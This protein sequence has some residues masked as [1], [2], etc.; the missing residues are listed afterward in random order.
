MNTLLFSVSDI[1]KYWDTITQYVNPIT[2]VKQAVI[3]GFVGFLIV[4]ITMIVLRKK[5]LINRRHWSLKILSYVYMVF[6]PLFAGYCFTQWFGVHAIEKEL[7]KNIPTYLGDANSAFNKYLKAEVEKVVAERHL[8][9]TGHEVLDKGVDMAANTVSSL[10]QTA[11]DKLETQLS[12]YLTKT[13]FVKDMAV[14]HIVEKLGEQLLMD[15]ELTHAVLDVKIQNLLDDG[16]L[17]TVIEKH[18]K[19]I[20]GGFKMNALLIFFIGLL[21]PAAEILLAH[22]LEKKRLTSETPPTPPTQEI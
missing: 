19:N 8:K 9:L 3:G 14:N 11:D 1:F 2:I 18:I 20:T 13:N 16:V 22:Y 21:I 10:L 12:A 6:L 4:L 5:I 17:N 15:K 7:V